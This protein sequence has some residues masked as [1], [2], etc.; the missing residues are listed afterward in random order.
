MDPDARWEGDFVAAGWSWTPWAG[1]HLASCISRTTFPCPVCCICW[2]L[3]QLLG[4]PEPRNSLSSTLWQT[5]SHCLSQHYLPE[6]RCKAYHTSQMLVFLARMQQ[7]PFTVSV[8]RASLSHME[9]THILTSRVKH[10]HWCFPPL[11]VYIFPL[12][13]FQSYWTV[14]SLSKNKGHDGLDICYW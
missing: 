6:P 13:Q 14:L 3:L 2:G 9:M 12:I 7:E 11:N 5:K 1:D 10:F 8:P 4:H